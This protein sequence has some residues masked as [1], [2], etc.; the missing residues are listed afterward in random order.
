MM[1]STKVADLT[2]DELKNVIRETV[3]QTL[4]ELLSD[5]DEEL[6]LREKLSSELLASFQE[7]KAHYKTAQTIAEDLDLNW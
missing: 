7:T 1:N 4:V 5:P 3:T 2:V 6:V